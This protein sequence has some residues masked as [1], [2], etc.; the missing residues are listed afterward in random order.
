MTIS[1]RATAKNAALDA[2]LANI[3]LLRLYDGTQPA[4]PETALGGGNH[5]LAEL[6][7]TPGAASAGASTIVLVDDTD[8]DATGTVT[9][10]S[11][12][13]ADGTRQIDIPLADLGLDSASVIQHGLVRGGSF[14]YTHG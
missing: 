14:V 10:G 13:K 5:Q 1:V 8:A 2:E 12:C 3:T 7:A 6:G 9:F 11:L 4:S